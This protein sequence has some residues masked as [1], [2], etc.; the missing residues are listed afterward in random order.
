MPDREQILQT[1]E[2]AYAARVRGDREAL[3][4]HWAPDALFRIAGRADLIADLPM[5]EADPS[6]AR[7]IEL[8]RFHDLERIDAVVE[9]NTAAIHWRV[10]VSAGDC[11]PV[12]TELFDLFKIG[13][14]GEIL[15][16]VQ[17]GDTAL[18]AHLL[19]EAEAAA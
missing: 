10:R 8:F 16:L 17:F 18:I 4:A 1:I 6:V 7:L 12:E 14:G 13:P 3:A 2:E 19:R 5:G 9:G 11:E 15:S